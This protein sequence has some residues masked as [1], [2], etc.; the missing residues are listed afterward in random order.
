MISIQKSLTTFK[1]KEKNETEK[2]ILKSSVA[3]KRLVIR[4][5]YKSL[6]TIGET[7][8]ENFQKKELICLPSITNV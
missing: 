2:R 7:T 6:E 1:S 3:I 4:C 8:P 5:I